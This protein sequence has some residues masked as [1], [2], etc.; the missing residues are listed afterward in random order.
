MTSSDPESMGLLQGMTKSSLNSGSSEFSTTLVF[1]LK[2]IVH[3]RR[4]RRR[5]KERRSD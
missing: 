1:V 5:K 4:R 2:S 3:K